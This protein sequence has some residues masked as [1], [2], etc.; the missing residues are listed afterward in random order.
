MHNIAKQIEGL[1]MSNSR[2]DMNESLGSLI[3]E[4]IISQVL[5]PERLLMEHI[6]LIAIL[7]ANIGTEVGK[8]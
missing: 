3:N 8:F 6:L 2:N 5:T 7:H 4:S 1:Y